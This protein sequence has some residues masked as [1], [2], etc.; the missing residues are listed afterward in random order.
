M[1]GELLV[2]EAMSRG[3][4]AVVVRPA[5]IYGPGDTRFLKLFRGIQK[6]SFPIIGDGKTLYHFTYIDDLVDGFLLA[7][8]S[9]NAVGEVVH[10][11]RR[12]SRHDP[13]SSPPWTVGR[14]AASAAAHPAWPVHS[15]PCC[16][17]RC[18]SRSASIHRCIR[19]VSSSSRST[20]RSR[21]PRPAGCSVTNR[22]CR[23]KMVSRA[24]ARGI[25]KAGCCKWNRQP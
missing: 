12:P 13:Q 5:G 7:G 24:R 9:P 25:G 6:G 18:A 15:P 1:E 20:V 22:R 23:S 21:L 11:R 16:A 19:G 8:E 14:Q 17:S 3:Q 2:R 4:A 10:D